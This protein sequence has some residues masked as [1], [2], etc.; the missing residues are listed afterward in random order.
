M[1]LVQH[2]TAP[3]AHAFV[4]TSGFATLPISL[5]IGE[6]TQAVAVTTINAQQFSVHIAGETYHIHLETLHGTRVGYRTRTDTAAAQHAPAHYAQQGDTLWLCDASGVYTFTDATYAPPAS[7]HGASDGVIKA[8]MDGRI[9]AV[10]CAA[11]D[12][13]TKGQTLATLEAMKMEMPLVAR[14]D[15]TV[16]HVLVS[17]GQQVKGKQILL[18]IA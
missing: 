17:I 12:A 10:N 5:K 8:P 13:V 6:S 15:G 7:A 2:N 18:K 16:S 4:R 11:G 1:L 3:S 9:M 14:A